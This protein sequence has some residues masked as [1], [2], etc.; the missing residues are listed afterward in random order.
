LKYQKKPVYRVTP[1]LQLLIASRW[2]SNRIF[3]RT[4][5]D[6]D[7]IWEPWVELYHTGNLNPAVTVALWCLVGIA[8][9]VFWWKW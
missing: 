5:T 9:L 6:D 7:G 8:I 4:K 1:R 2:N 3:Y